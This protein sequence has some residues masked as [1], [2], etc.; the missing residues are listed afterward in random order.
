MNLSRI[1]DWI[2]DALWRIGGLGAAADL[3]LDSLGSAGYEPCP[4]EALFPDCASL[5]AVPCRIPCSNS[6]P[7]RPYRS[8]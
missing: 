7:K 5:E 1:I 8:R 6:S 4:R 2:R 3:G